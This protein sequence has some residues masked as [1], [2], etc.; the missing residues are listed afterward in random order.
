MQALPEFDP[1]SWFTIMDRKVLGE[2]FGTPDELKAALEA[3]VNEWNLLLA[4]SFQWSYDGKGEHEKAVKCFTKML[5][6]STGKMELH[7]LTKQ[8]VLLSNLLKDY[9]SKIARE[10]WGQLFAALYDQSEM[11]DD[12]I[13][14]ESGPF[15]KH[16]AQQA[17]SNL[18]AEFCDYFVFT[19]EMGI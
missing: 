15:R 17:A 8:M 19:K 5:R 14:G 10:S 3:F 16:K 4:H 6:R 11:I 1:A 7:T 13:Q 9:L 12:I 2:L 18:T